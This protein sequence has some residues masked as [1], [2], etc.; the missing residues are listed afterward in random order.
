MKD[1]LIITVGSDKLSLDRLQG[2]AATVV[3]K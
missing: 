3:V 2:L 1:G